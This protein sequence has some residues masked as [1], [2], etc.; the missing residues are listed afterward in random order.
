MSRNSPR[1]IVLSWSGGKD[2]A[3]ALARLR[4]DPGFAVV[5]LLTTVSA[6][7]DRIS[8]HGVRRS[9]LQQQA[10]ALGL[11]VHEV[12]VEPQCSNEAYEAAWRLALKTLPTE[13]ASARHIAFGD[14]FLADVRTYREDM[15]R[16]AGYEAVFPLWGE[17]T[18]SLAREVVAAAFAARIV[19]VDT[20]VLDASFAGRPY[21]DAFLAALPESVDPCGE[22]GEFHTFVAAGP[23]FYAPVMYDV[24]DTVLRD[25]RFAYCDLIPRPAAEG[26]ARA[27]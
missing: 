23:G 5:G 2:S 8:I 12:T 20:Y 14:I 26:A 16:A 6:A 7:Y 17:A 3:L 21:D 11:R 27:S 15:T 18:H 25:E 4:R 24:G 9:L 10:A 22:Q 19:C 1:P 13:L